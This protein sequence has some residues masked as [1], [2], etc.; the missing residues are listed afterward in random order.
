M[1]KVRVSPSC[2]PFPTTF[3]HRLALV[4]VKL[5]VTPR[6]ASARTTR[7]S[8][9]A[10]D[11]FRR[12]TDLRRNEGCEG[13]QHPDG[14]ARGGIDA[15]PFPPPPQP[16]THANW[17]PFCRSHSCRAAPSPHSWKAPAHAPRRTPTDL[18]FQS[19]PNGTLCVWVGKIQGQLHAGTRVRPRRRPKCERVRP[20]R[21]TS[22]SPPF[23]SSHSSLSS[24]QSSLLSVLG[25]E[26]WWC[27]CGAVCR[28]LTPLFPPCS[29][30][31]ASPLLLLN[32]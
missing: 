9:A 18:R 12:N 29:H 17:F 14:R 22:S 31:F 10:A 21:P 8:S 19:C 11:S 1:K 25:E 5:G 28:A 30:S 4:D 24:F 16:L 32:P 3:T 15:P 23:V 26:R 6:R 27:E 13:G 20:C 2:S 7:S